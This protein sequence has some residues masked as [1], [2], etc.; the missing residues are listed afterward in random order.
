MK[1]RPKLPHVST[2]VLLSL[3]VSASLRAGEGSSKPALEESRGSSTE[4]RLSSLEERLERLENG[5]ERVL[6]RL[7]ALNSPTEARSVRNEAEELATE[8]SELSGSVANHSASPPGES[9]QQADPTDTA[10][11]E[12][13]VQASRVSYG[14][15]MELHLNH[16]NVNPTTLDFHRF[17]LLYGH[18]FNDRIRF[19]GE[20]EVEHALVEGG[21]ASG[22]LELEQAYLDFLLLPNLSFRA[23]MMLTPMGIINERHEP[24]S[25]NGVERPFVD[26]FIVPSTWFSNGAGLVGELGG[27]FSFKA[28]AMSSLNGSFFSADEGFRGGRQ[29]GFFD[30]ASN[31]SAVGRLEYS[32]V[33]NLNL[34]V[35]YWSGNTALDLDGVSGRAGI[36]EFDGQYSFKRFDFRGQFALTHL[37]DAEEINRAQQRTSGVNPNVAEK[38][39][40]FYSEGAFHLLSDDTAHDLVAFYRFENFNTQYRMPDGFLPLQQFDRDAHVIGVTYFPHPD[41][42]FKFDYNFM[43]NA[44]QVVRIP[45]RWNFGIGWWF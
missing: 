3:L 36:F 11:S 8:L 25:F 13:I 23:G 37:D 45:N 38:M 29:K 35:S 2:A 21:E 14:G 7:S 44:S 41:I 32:G 22:E 20:V 40:G 9:G 30:N 24:A 6:D 43:G 34:G 16:D 33:D 42:A 19:V 17:V 4:E 18:Q 5:L 1:I 27:G 15:Y 28:F 26:S 31:I 10:S 39:L 12:P